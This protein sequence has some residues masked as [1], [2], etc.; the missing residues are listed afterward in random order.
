MNTWR[1]FLVMLGIATVA[2]AADWPQWLGPKRDGVSTEAVEM[3]QGEL[4]PAWS[5]P[6]GA[7]YAAPVVVAGR[8]FVHSRPAGQDR[9]EMICFEASTGKELWRTG[10]DRA[11]YSSILSTGPQATPAVAGGKVFGFG[12][13]GIL[14]CFDTATG[15]MLWKTEA[16]KKFDQN[17]PRFGVCCSPAVVGNRVVVAIGGKGHSIVAFDTATGEPAWQALDESA[18]TSSPLI[19]AVQGQIV[20]DVV[21][22]TT[23]RVVALNPLDGS[24]HWEFPLPYQPMGT[25][26]TPILSGD[27]LF[28]STMDNGTTGIRLQTGEKVQGQK[29]WQSKN[30]AGYFSTGVASKDHVYLVTNQLKPVPRADLVCVERE[31]GKQVWKEEGVGYF[32]FG[33]LRTANDRLLILTDGGV[34][35]LLDLTATGYKE[36][37]KAKICEGTF[38]TPSFADGC[39]FARDGS[40]VV[41]VRL[42]PASEKK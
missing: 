10:Y 20:P 18:N 29:L 6:V 23:L 40:K 5:M 31:T 39:V 28:T 24:I 37:G 34:L 38:V 22:M 4:K 41:C 7:G 3:W 15:K 16:L 14:T 19:V 11:A 26:P 33:M 32:H 9:E 30:L 17:V 35:R 1:C 12:I 36:L 13:T 42:A 21:F 27:T 8:V 2:G 25:A